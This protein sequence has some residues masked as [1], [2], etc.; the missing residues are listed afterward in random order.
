ML[1][2]VSLKHKTTLMTSLLFYFIKNHFQHKKNNLLLKMLIL[3]YFV[4]F[5]DMSQDMS[6]ATGSINYIALTRFNLA[7]FR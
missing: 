3:G 6:L 5:K 4:L 7:L 2:F 1:S